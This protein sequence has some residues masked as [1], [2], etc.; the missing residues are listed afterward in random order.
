MTSV[1]GFVGSPLAG[2]LAPL[3]GEGEALNGGRSALPFSTLPSGGPT[4]AVDALT[5]ILQQKVS[6]ESAAGAPF[7]AEVNRFISPLLSGGS[8]IAFTNAQS[9]STNGALNDV[10]LHNAFI[11]VRW[12]D[13]SERVIREGTP[14]FAL[15]SDLN[16]TPPGYAV[17]ASPV[18]LNTLQ[19]RLAQLERAV[20]FNGVVAE[21]DDPRRMRFRAENGAHA[22]SDALTPRYGEEGGVDN[23]EL[24]HY[25]YFGAKTP[26]EGFEK[27]NYVGPVLQVHSRENGSSSI[28]ARQTFALGESYISHAWGTRAYVANLFATEPELGDQLYFSLGKYDRDQLRRVGIKSTPEYTGMAYKRAHS[29]ISS[30]FVGAHDNDANLVTQV[31]GWSSRDG[32]QWLSKTSPIDSM[33]PEAADRFY[34]ERERRAATEYRD[35]EVTE[36]GELKFKLNTDDIQEKINNLPSIVIENYLD[37]VF[38]YPVGTVKNN[39]ETKTTSAAIFNAHYDTDAL[40]SQHLLEVYINA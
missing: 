16:V 15:H 10:Q 11:A 22:Q 30:A 13:G 33:K 4:S 37:S 1:S 31:R 34:L 35:T 14:L 2:T 32:Q 5:S 20:Q 3:L 17:V 7:S 26:Q 39:L 28:F 25:R 27:W 8:R 24:L 36:A 40:N 9:L 23:S 29:S 18:K 6:S 12:P 21:V 19:L 38:I